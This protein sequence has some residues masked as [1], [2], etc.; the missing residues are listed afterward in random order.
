MLYPTELL[1]QDFLGPLP[2]GAAIGTGE[3]RANENSR[4]Y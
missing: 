2:I 1:G 4:S 3:G